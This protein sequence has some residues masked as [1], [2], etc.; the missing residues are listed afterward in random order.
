MKKLLLFALAVSV[1]LTVN[2][3]TSRTAA[4]VK[5]YSVSVKMKPMKAENATTAVDNQVPY[6]LGP[7]PAVKNHSHYSSRTSSTFVETLIGKT[8]YD[9]QSNRGTAKRI[10]NNLDGTLS[11]V[12]TMTPIGG[13]NGVDRGT[14]YNYYD[15]TT[16]GP[17]PTVRIDPIRV[18]F[19]NID[20]TPQAGEWTCAHTGAQGLMCDHRPV[21]GTGPWDTTF[22]GTSNLLANQADVWARFALGG[23]NG[24]SVHAIVNSQ[25]TGTTPVLAQNGPLT[26]SRSTDGG[27]TWVDDHIQIPGTDSSFM[28]G[29]GAEEYH[30]DA[31][32]DV[33]AV[34]TGGFTNDV[35]LFK[36][37]D[38]GATWSRRVVSAFP[39]GQP[40]DAATQNTDTTGDGIG[41]QIE[42]NA[43]DVTVTIDNNNMCHL[44]WGHMVVSEDAGAT[45]ESFFPTDPT[46]ILYWNENMGAS[47]PIVIAAPQD[48]NGN[49]KI[50]IAT[51]PNDTT[52]PGFGVYNVGL[53]G[54]PSI[55]IDANNRVFVAYSALDERA[56]TTAWQESFK[57]IFVVGSPD[58]G[59][60]WS[61]PFTVNPSPDGDF[62]EAVWPSV[63]TVVSNNCI[64]I[65]YQRDPAP[66]HTLGA[67]A[68]QVA[69]NQL[70]PSDIIYVCVAPSEV[71]GVK[72]HNTASNDWVSANHPNPVN[73]F[74]T[75]DVTLT[76]TSD[77]SLEIT[78]TLGQVVYSEKHNGTNAGVM[79]IRVDATHFDAGVYFYTVTAGDQKV[80]RKMI[81][82]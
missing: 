16:W 47:A 42:S 64:H 49:G 24:I 68:G 43:G 32:G 65:V 5:N 53:A 7:L 10:S 15:G 27:M 63:A 12:W 60:T 31:R 56:D 82:E 8:I 4:G 71:L 33:V 28:A 20:W 79:S 29:V 75:I 78:N 41:E 69:N 2:S 45:N 66:G 18:G 38:N 59:A 57:H 77:V 74:T 55:G 34:V 1:S 73:G 21:K 11:A 9:L 3:Q 26:Y 22:V 17:I 25:G 37:L 23:A 30:I 13:S 40:Y 67:N 19:V 44:A 51:N 52:D 61:A 50:D 72:E 39:L 36:S 46:G 35:V 80:S 81:V 76:K 6:R 48:F 58:G 14:G 62:Q 70:S 54:Q